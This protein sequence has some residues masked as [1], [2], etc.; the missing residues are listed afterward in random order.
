M[1][2]VAAQAAV[3]AP[4]TFRRKEIEGELN[5][6]S[7][8]DALDAALEADNIVCR[9]NNPDPEGEPIDFEMRPMTPGEMA[10]YYQTLL[11]HTLLEAA[12]G[13]PNP[14]TEFN[15]EQAQRVQDELTVKKYDEKLLNILEGCIQSPVGVTAERMKKW[16][17]FY[18]QSLHNSL[19][20][21][22]RPSKM[23]ARFSDVGE[24][25]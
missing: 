17:P 24:E 3:N 10:I 6:I 16:D 15:D 18:I 12:A 20:N 21:G 25:S 4:Q 7:D 9:F 14:D 2:D 19:M 13:N 8:L 5:F 1:A 22:S 23:V 11:G